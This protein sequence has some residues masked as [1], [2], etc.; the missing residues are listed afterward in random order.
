MYPDWHDLIQRYIAGLTTEEEASLLQDSLKEDDALARLYLR[1]TNLDVALEAHASSGSSMRELL[2]ETNPGEAKRWTQ[3]LSWRPLAAAVAG[4][5]IGLLSASILWAVTTPRATSE[6]LFSLVNGGF[7]ESRLEA[8][9]PRQTGVWSGDE[10]EI[11][12]GQLCFIRP[13]ADATDPISRAISCDVFQL[14]DLRPLGRGLSQEGDSVLELR[15]KFLDARPHNTKPSVTFFCQIYLFK[16]D[17]AAS[18]ES[19]PQTIPEALSSGS[20]QTTTQGSDLTEWNL[21]TAKCLVPVDADYA[22]IQIAARPNL[23]P[24]KL[25]SLFADNIELTLK[26]KPSLPVSIVRR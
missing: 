16:G 18:G 6:R 19:W 21:L 24:A 17:P 22:V 9:F 20:A 4:L 1:Y 23:R 25:E 14:V 26:T 5:F 12:D 13:G 3:S 7:D 10:A 8:G 11:S 15:A 2:M